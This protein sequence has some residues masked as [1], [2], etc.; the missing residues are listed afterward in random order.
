VEGEGRP[1]PEKRQKRV[2]YRE[3]LPAEEFAI[4][5]NLRHLRKELAEQEGVPVYALFSN[6][7]LA[8]MVRQR[9]ISLEGLHAIEGVGKARLEKYGEAFIR[10][11]K[12]DIPA[13]SPGSS[14]TEEPHDLKRPTEAA[15]QVACSL[16]ACGSHH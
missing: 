1:R 10:I 7:Q 13:L 6:D 5:S 14:A 11:L 16:E 8:A 3:V 2:D 9:V 15:S 12:R 4:F